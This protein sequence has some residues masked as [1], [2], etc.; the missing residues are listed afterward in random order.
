MKLWNF[1]HKQYLNSYDNKCFFWYSAIAYLTFGD[2]Y[3]HF[4]TDILPITPWGINSVNTKI[5]VL[6]NET[7]F[8]LFE[9]N[10]WFNSEVMIIFIGC[11]FVY[12]WDVIYLWV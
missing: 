5:K 8:L 1:P 4:Y 10:S 11:K 6:P 3:S 12:P 2:L 7:T 9:V